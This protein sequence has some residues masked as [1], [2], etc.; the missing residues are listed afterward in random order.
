M[1]MMEKLRNKP[2][3]DSAGIEHKTFALDAL[4]TKPLESLGNLFL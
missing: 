4:S 3:R 1:V 2:T